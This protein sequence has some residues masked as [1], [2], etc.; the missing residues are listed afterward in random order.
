MEYS[1]QRRTEELD[2]TGESRRLSC[3]TSLY[4]RDDGDDVVECFERA[5]DILAG[6]VDD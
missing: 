4:G 1:Q 3:V 2:F 5:K 6:A